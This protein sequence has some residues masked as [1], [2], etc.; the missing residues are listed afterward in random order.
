MVKERKFN[1][2]PDV[3]S[4]LAYLR[5][6]TELGVRSSETKADKPEH[7]LSKGR[8]AARRAKGKPTE[9]PYLSKKAQKVLKERKEIQKE[10][11]E[12][13][14]EVDKEERASNVRFSVFCSYLRLW[15]ID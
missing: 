15:Q 1:I 6:K 5:L 14:A 3:L 7:M 12:A 4:C 10:M 13:A 8:Q 9:Q 11:Q 2:H